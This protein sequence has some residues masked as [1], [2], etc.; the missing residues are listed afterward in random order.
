VQAPKG[1]NYLLVK[2]KPGE[3][4]AY[5]PPLAWLAVAQGGVSTN[6]SLSAGDLAVFDPADAPI[7]LS[8]AG[9]TDAM[10]VLGSAVP[11]N[12]ALHMG[13]YSVHTSAEALDR[14]ERRIAELRRKLA[15]AGDRR[16]NSGSTPV[17]RGPRP[18]QFGRPMT[19]LPA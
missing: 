3:S 1:F 18:R 16:N 4:W 19:L 8:T 7:S 9:E 5:E 15:E 2:L 10:F 13:N 17:F 11:H 6:E 12:Y 14:G